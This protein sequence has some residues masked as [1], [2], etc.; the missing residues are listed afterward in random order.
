MSFISETVRDWINVMQM[1]YPSGH[2]DH[3]FEDFWNL[4]R[5]GKCHLCLKPLGAS[6]RSMDTPWI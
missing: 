6:Y 4:G 1:L 3:L 2:L 5:N